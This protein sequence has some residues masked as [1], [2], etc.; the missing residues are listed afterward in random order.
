MEKQCICIFSN[1]GCIY[2][3]IF[4]IINF[5]YLQIY[6]VMYVPSFNHFV[7]KYLILAIKRHKNEKKETT[8][9]D[10]SQF[11]HV[12]CNYRNIYIYIKKYILLYHTRWLV[13]GGTSEK[14]VIL[15]EKRSRKY[16]IKIFRLRLCFQENRF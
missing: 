10:L 8:K 4:F 9:I 7:L 16:R 1:N 3:K 15:H 5:R 13:I 14:E 6:Q 12:T 11:F 2:L